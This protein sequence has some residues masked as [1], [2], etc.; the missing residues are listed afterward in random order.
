MLH[1]IGRFQ[2][3]ERPRQA[4]AASM[5]RRAALVAAEH[6]HADPREVLSARRRKGEV[7]S[8][9]VL[10]AYLAVVCFNLSRRQ[11]ARLTGRNVMLISRFCASIETARD[12]RTIDAEIDRLEARL[13]G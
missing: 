1:A 2:S 6:C 10:A 9:R 5:Y 13:I 11:V 12:S 3:R 8:A 4:R 7:A